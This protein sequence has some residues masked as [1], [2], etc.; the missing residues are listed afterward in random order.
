VLLVENS[1]Q[2][3]PHFCNSPALCIHN[4]TKLWCNVKYFCPFVAFVTRLTGSIAAGIPGINFPALFTTVT[5]V[6]LFPQVPHLL[7]YL[8]A[9][10][11][12]GKIKFDQN[13]K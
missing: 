10:F 1:L 6:I 5:Q 13:E 7:F 11:F 4:Q 9:V 12:W 3:S 8:S 2:A